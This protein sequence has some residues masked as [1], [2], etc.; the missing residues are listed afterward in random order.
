MSLT[1]S[2]GLPDPVY[3]HAF[4]DG[5]PAKRFFAWLVDA[6]I[7]TIVTFLLGLVTLSLLWWVWPVTFILTSFLYRTGTIAT[8]SATWGMRL[9]NIEL[10]GPTGARLTTGEAAVHTLGYMVATGFVILQLISMGMMAFGARGQGLHD[11][12]IGSTAINR[13]H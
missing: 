5:V 13:P 9:L 6:V 12:L 3:D 10:R 2:R 11:L 8:G 1:M 4:Y 7:V